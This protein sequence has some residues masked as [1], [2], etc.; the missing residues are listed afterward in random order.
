MLG[1]LVLNVDFLTGIGLAAAITVAFAVV[2]AITLLP[3]LFGILGMR[4]L[5]RRE[6]R[7]ISRRPQPAAP[8]TAGLGPVG[9]VRA[10]TPGAAQ[11]RPRS[12]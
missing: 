4:V 7:R 3:A 11:R 8:T 6:R 5:S 2:A 10:T 1:L 12:P 9:G